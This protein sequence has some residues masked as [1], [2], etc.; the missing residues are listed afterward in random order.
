MLERVH[1]SQNCVTLLF[2]IFQ[3]VLADIDAVMVISVTRYLNTISPKF[4]KKVAQNIKISTSKLFLKD[5]NF[6]I[7]LLLKPLNKPCAKTA[8]LGEN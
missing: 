4:W 1:V 8:C 3:I 6:H 7:K 2:S 5:Q